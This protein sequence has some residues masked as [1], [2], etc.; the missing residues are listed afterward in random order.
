MGTKIKIVEVLKNA[1]FGSFSNFNVLPRPHGLFFQQNCFENIQ[2][3][4]KGID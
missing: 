4:H 3:Q 2:V 1:F